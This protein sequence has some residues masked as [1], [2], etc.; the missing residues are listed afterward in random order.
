MEQ[1]EDGKTL[2]VEQKVSED[3]KPKETNLKADDEELTLPESVGQPTLFGSVTKEQPAFI[4]EQ[5]L[6]DREM[7]A[8]LSLSSDPVSELLTSSPSPTVPSE[9]DRKWQFKEGILEKTQ[10]LL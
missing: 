8:G 5:L 3:Q 2:K 7:D 9:G 10:E 6:V 4:C 1:S